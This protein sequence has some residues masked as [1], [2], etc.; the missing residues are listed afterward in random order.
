MP[1][2]H[3]HLWWEDRLIVD[4]DGVDLPD[5]KT[6]QGERAGAREGWEAVLHWMPLLPCR[7]TVVTDETG[8]VLFVLAL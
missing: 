1:R 8:R 2:Y 7:T 4:Q 6:E 5:P 3:F